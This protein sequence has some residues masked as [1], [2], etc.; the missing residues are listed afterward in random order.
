MGWFKQKHMRTLVRRFWGG[1]ILSIL[2]VAV[3][4]QLG[5]EAFPMLNDYR[6]YISEQLSDTL[7]V[8]VEI[9]AIK[10]RW[11][12]LHPR[13]EFRDLTMFA[14][15]GQQ[16]LAVGNLIGELSLPSSLREWQLVWRQ[17]EFSELHMQFDQ[18]ADGQWTLGGLSLARPQTDDQPMIDPLDIFLLSRHLTLDQSTLEFVFRTGHRADIIIPQLNLEN[19]TDFHRL[20]ANFAV[21]GDTEAFSVVIEG[22]GNPRSKDD[23][24]AEGYIELESFPMEKV[25]AAL[26]FDIWDAAG[27][28]EWSEGH[29]L[30]ASLWFSGTPYR[31]MTLQGHLRADGLPLK[32]PDNMQLPT[33]LQSEVTG[34]WQTGAGWQLAL[35]QAQLAWGDASA[36]TFDV[37]LSGGEGYPLRVAVDQIDLDQWYPLARAQGFV[38][39]KLAEVLDALNPRGQ[40]FNLVVEKKP[41]AEGHF[42]L[43][44][45]FRDAQVDAFIGAPALDSVDGYVEVSAYDGRVVV[46][47]GNGFSMFY[48][49]VYHEPM[50]YQKAAGE[51]RWAIRKPLQRVEVW[52]GR[53]SLSGEEGEGRGYIHLVLPYGEE[54]HPGPQMTLLVGLQNSHARFHEK[55]VPYKIPEALYQ[56][57][58]ASIKGGEISRAG[59]LWH[60][61]LIPEDEKPSP[62]IQLFGRIADAS[63]QFSPDWPP[64]VQAKGSLLLDNHY[65]QVD[66]SEALLEQN[67]VQDATVRLTPDNPD[68]LQISGSA[69]GDLA[70]A[71]RLLRNSPVG[72][73][74]GPNFRGWRG[75]GPVDAEI[76]ISVPL[77]GENAGHQ[78]VQAQI[79]GAQLT[80]PELRLPLQDIRGA[81]T[82]STAEG[83]N[84]PGLNFNL[85]GHAGRAAIASPQTGNKGMNLQIDVTG[86]ASVQSLADW[87]K[88]PE[89][90][91]AAEGVA[92][93]E[94]RLVIPTTDE[95][96]TTALFSSNLAGVE[97]LLPEPYG[98]PA[99]QP[100]SLDVNVVLDEM[101]QYR[102]AYGDLLRLQ[103]ILDD[104][105]HSASLAL[106]GPYVPTQQGYFD[107]SGYLGDIS[108]EPWQ[109]LFA[110]LGSAFDKSQFNETGSNDTGS[111]ET[112]PNEHS[113]TTAMTDWPL[114]PRFDVYLQSLQLEK[115]D[116]E[117][118]HLKG[119]YDQQRWRV[120]I[121]SPR[122]QGE[123][124]VFNNERPLQLD[125]RS[126]QLPG[127]ES[128]ARETASTEGEADAAKQPSLLSNIDLGRIPA[129]DF[130]TQSLNIG[131]KHYG[132]WAFN[133]RPIRNGLR[134]NN[135][136]GHAL[137]LQIG[138]VND[139]AEMLWVQTGERHTTHIKGVVRAGNLG[140]V[141]QA[142]GQPGIMESESARFDVEFHW[143]G[144]PDDVDVHQL[145]GE[146]T[147]DIRDGR[148][149]RGAE[150]GNNPF[151]RLFGLLN[152][153]T[154]VR[155]LRLDFSD[156]YKEGL[157][158]DSVTG[159]LQFSDDKV[160][161]REPLRVEAP[162]STLQFTGVLDVAT[163][164]VDATLVATLPVS[165]NL[166]VAAAF[167]GGLP[168]AVGVYVVSKLFEEQVDKASSIRYGITGFWN[169]PEIRVERIFDSS[170]E[171]GAPP[172]IETDDVQQPKRRRAGPSSR[173]PALENRRPPQL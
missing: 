131:D 119:D 106:G 144:A 7:G 65:L 98:K 63:L 75:T 140:D 28:G 69:T 53:M 6:D 112:R 1:I 70:N 49:M 44:S 136:K 161:M 46:D 37:Q 118:L 5:R 169:D 145:E 79:D 167:V 41:A 93:V 120:N 33:G 159:K 61:P 76:E 146:V 115:L 117:R 90:A 111:N 88:R 92:Q 137:G 139:P 17:L 102:I 64:V 22:H 141:A 97:L 114:M 81:L 62:A 107:I 34:Q 40:L 157:V 150:A 23:F 8:D 94:G 89:L 99:A 10:A 39:G 14:Q 171:N 154:L 149:I 20:I 67:Q 51:V 12:G 21:D 9:G 152:F 133:L 77:G 135:I 95:S 2:V 43:R 168:A 104:Q 163:E 125:L 165:G 162:S 82:Y 138:D 109:A 3:C 36:P 26:D 32:T 134:L 100:A 4:V 11:V 35:K 84:S 74:L 172:V 113:P 57:L 105:L 68:Q 124:K 142:L 18:A 151:L 143:P 29:R 31:S 110:R 73:R 108:L 153:D 87:L 42:F 155:R 116:V 80:L 25:V 13:V 58:Q 27:S 166:A 85:W 130:S 55:Y 24:T 59:F 91:L 147:A 158:F 50:A 66:V 148:F 96:N 38:S 83:L 56:W 19:E 123:V 128:E 170:T 164:K 30:D 71:L 103:F 54:P 129:V 52:S 78:R 127:K 86:S 45:N 126:L 160:L 47:S 60:G 101:Q 121:E 16:I 15:D 132:S 48:P 122:L 173:E 72:A 156:L